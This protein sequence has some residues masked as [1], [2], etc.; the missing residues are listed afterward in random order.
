MSIFNMIVLSVSRN[1][2]FVFAMKKRLCLTLIALLFFLQVMF[3]YDKYFGNQVDIRLTNVSVTKIWEFKVMCHTEK[4]YNIPILSEDIKRT[5]NEEKLINQEIFGPV[6]LDKTP[7]I[8]VVQVHDRINH[9]RYLIKSLSIAKGINETLLIFSHDVW[10]E[11]INDLVKSIK[12]AKVLQIYYPF[13]IQTHE[14]SFPGDSPNDC[15]SWATKQEAKKLGCINAEWPDQY[16]HYRKA[17]F[18]Q[19][20][21]HWWWKV[22]QVFD[23]L[24]TIRNFTGMILF[25]EEDHYLSEDFLVVLSQMEDQRKI[26]NTTYDI[27][28]LGTHAT[29]SSKNKKTY[30]EVGLTY[31]NHGKHN[32]GMAFDR[33]IWEKLKS[34]K[35]A[36]CKFDDYNWDFSLT[37]VSESCLK[38]KLRTVFLKGSRIFHIGKCGFHNNKNDECDIKE[39][40]RTTVSKLEQLQPLLY[41]TNLTI[42]NF[43]STT[44]KKLLGNGGWGDKRDQDMCMNIS[45]LNSDSIEQYLADLNEINKKD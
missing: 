39:V 40:I 3:F 23:Q 9:L 8:I 30:N 19:I 12:F 21:H 43:K 31:W 15:P 17:K 24:H 45:S 14:N 41:P 32:M 10:D 38:E 25:I 4:V 36:F 37:H 22:H 28:C 5:N 11:E 33:M 29:K 26:E 13:S 7:T 2:F 16:N 20:K 34:C 18:T 6:N 35:T 42:E 44:T 27:L 1:K